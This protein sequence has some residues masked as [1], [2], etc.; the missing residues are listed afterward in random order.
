MGEVELKRK[1]S[2]GKKIA[3]P[4][5]PTPHKISNTLNVNQKTNKR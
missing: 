2:L 5:H 4:L 3:M 1:K